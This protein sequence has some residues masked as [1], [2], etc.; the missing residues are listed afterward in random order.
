MENMHTDGGCKDLLIIFGVVAR[1]EE[2]ETD[3]EAYCTGEEPENQSVEEHK[4]VILHLVSQL[5]LG[6]DLT[7]VPC[8][9]LEMCTG[10]GSVETSNSSTR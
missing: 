10:L 9:V 8:G 1:R 7:K 5:K 4:S 3:H 6:M 2:E